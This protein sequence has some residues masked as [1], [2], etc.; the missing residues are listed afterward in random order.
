MQGNQYKLLPVCVMVECLGTN[1][2]TLAC[3]QSPGRP[4]PLRFVPGRPYS[5]TARPPKTKAIIPFPVGKLKI[6]T[7]A[8]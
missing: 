4:S 3:S 6:K 5:P 8:Y 1:I 2:A 7:S